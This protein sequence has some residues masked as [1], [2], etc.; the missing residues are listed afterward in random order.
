MQAKKMMGALLLATGFLTL[1]CGGVEENE[2]DQNLSQTEQSVTASCS[3]G[4]SLSYSYWTCEPACPGIYWG[5]I[6]RGVCSNGT[7]SYEIT[8]R[9]VCG[10]PCY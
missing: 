1:G 10:Q 9:L 8:V 4:Y 6:L 2:S 7:D 3:P 5:N